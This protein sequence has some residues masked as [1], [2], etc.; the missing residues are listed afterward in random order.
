MEANS[1]WKDCRMMEGAEGA[2][3]QTWAAEEGVEEE[4]LPFCILTNLYG[5]FLKHL[6]K[7][8]NIFRRIIMYRRMV[9]R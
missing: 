4:D 6:I 7:V 1:D 5:E 3:R 9:D 2:D 8:V